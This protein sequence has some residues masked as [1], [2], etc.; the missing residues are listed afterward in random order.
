MNGVNF[1]SSELTFVA[2]YHHDRNTLTCSAVN[3]LISDVYCVY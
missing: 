2:H 1:T 3:P